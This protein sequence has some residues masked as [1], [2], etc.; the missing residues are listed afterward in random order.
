MSNVLN[1]FKKNKKVCACFS[2]HGYGKIDF[3]SKRK[4]LVLTNEEL[5]WYKNRIYELKDLTISCLNDIKINPK[6]QKAYEDLK[7]YGNEIKKIKK[8]LK[9]ANKVAKENGK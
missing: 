2:E 7:K 8:I 5:E 1:K 4:N 9:N 6:N 3:L